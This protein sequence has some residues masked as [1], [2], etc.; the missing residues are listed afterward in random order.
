[1]FSRD[2]HLEILFLVLSGLALL[3]LTVA[4]H[5][6]V[7][8]IFALVG[9]AAIPRRARVLELAHHAA[10]AGELVHEDLALVPDETLRP[11]FLAAYDALP[12]AARLR[13]RVVAGLMEE[14]VDGARP[15]PGAAATIRA[16]L[17]LDRDGGDRPVR[18]RRVL[19]GPIA[20]RY[21]ED[22]ASASS[23]PRPRMYSI[24]SRI[25]RP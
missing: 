11:I 21:R 23:R 5:Q 15:A 6:G 17:G 10:P 25:R 7:L 18:R 14:L 16:P 24:C 12:G 2:R 20:G 22:R 8:A 1:L 19:R 9:L 3:A 4:L 13:P